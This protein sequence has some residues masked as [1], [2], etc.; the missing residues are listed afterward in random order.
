M[1]TI[2]VH[3]IN[4]VKGPT[5][6]KPYKE[7]SNKEQSYKEQSYKEHVEPPPARF[8]LPHSNPIYCRNVFDFVFV[9][10]VGTPAYQPCGG[11]CVAAGDAHFF[12]QSH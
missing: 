9:G 8:R 4:H 6:D 1:L 7:Q 11:L 10:R 5:N 12:L 3:F 2:T